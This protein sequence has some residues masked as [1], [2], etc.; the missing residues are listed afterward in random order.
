MCILALT[1]SL[2]VAPVIGETTLLAW[3]AD[4]ATQAAS[5]GSGRNRLVM[6]E[7][8]ICFIW[9]ENNTET[10]FFIFSV[11]SDLMQTKYCYK[12]TIF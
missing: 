5:F 10:R 7:C 4:R 2:W 11:H 9:T 12:Y 1:E 3:G 8:G 6:R